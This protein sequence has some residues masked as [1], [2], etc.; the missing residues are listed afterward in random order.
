M[1]PL[2]PWCAGFPSCG[3]ASTVPLCPEPS[4]SGDCPLQPHLLVSSYIQDAA[5]PDHPCHVQGR[6]L[7]ATG[8][9]LVPTSC[10]E[11]PPQSTAVP[12]RLPWMSAPQPMP[13]SRS[14][15]QDKKAYPE[16]LAMAPR[17]FS[18][19][20][21]LPAG[22]W[23]VMFCGLRWSHNLHRPSCYLVP[24]VPR[25]RYSPTEP[26]TPPQALSQCRIGY[27]ELLSHVWPRPMGTRQRKS[28]LRFLTGSKV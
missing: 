23:C 13:W 22:N 19:D 9:N 17:V 6:G 11:L 16:P 27:R 25:G 4:H 2:V 3:R 14:C 5:K 12:P 18:P 8:H 21:C 28:R 10:Q 7:L 26:I 15:D 24:K 1:L 20:P